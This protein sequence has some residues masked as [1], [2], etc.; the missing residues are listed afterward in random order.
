MEQSTSDFAGFI[1]GF[2][3]RNLASIQRN[4]SVQLSE[5]QTRL[6]ILKGLVEKDEQ[7][8][9]TILPKLAEIQ[10][11]FNDPALSIVKRLVQ[12]GSLFNTLILS[13]GDVLLSKPPIL[14]QIKGI[15]RA[16]VDA[17]EASPSEQLNDAV[18]AIA[19]SFK[20]V[21]ARISPVPA[22]V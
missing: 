16:Y 18:N 6:A 13:H 15:L 20:E 7:I 10:N 11:T 21:Q 3:A 1:A 14:S 9:G 12:V 17:A 2:E 19:T 8:K 4:V 22:E 5:M